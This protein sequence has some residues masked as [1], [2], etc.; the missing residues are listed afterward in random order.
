MGRLSGNR[1]RGLFFPEPPEKIEKTGTEDA[2]VT[3]G[4]G[5][6]GDWLINRSG[7]DSVGF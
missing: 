5:F 1:G 6:P 2:N 7:V 4:G 3:G